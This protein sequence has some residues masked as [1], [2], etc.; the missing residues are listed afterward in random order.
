MT[1]IW[2]VANIQSTIDAIKK[3][4]KG[5]VFATYVRI[6]ILKV[7]HLALH[8][9]HGSRLTALTGSL[10]WGTPNRCRCVPDGKQ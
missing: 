2:D 5:H 6:T 3:A 7:F 8:G 10:A 4:G 9:L 1:E